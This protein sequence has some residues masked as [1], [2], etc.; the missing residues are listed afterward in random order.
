[1][2]EAKDVRNHWHH[3]AW[4]GLAL[5]LYA[6]FE[7]AWGYA[8]AALFLVAGVGLIRRHA[9]L[10]AIGSF[11][12]LLAPTVQSIPPILIAFPI[13]IGV[14]ALFTGGS[15]AGRRSAWLVVVAL[16]VALLPLAAALIPGTWS[17]WEGW[18][19]PEGITLVASL[20]AL[21]IWS[22]ATLRRRRPTA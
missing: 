18:Y 20:L 9:G 4:L 19:G 5:G 12:M 10:A 17:S 3:V 11:L 22:A 21:I 7:G 14:G 16:A 6:R 2:M 8:A 1:M 15:L 13:I